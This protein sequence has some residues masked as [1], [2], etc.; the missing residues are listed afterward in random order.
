[1]SQKSRKT[2]IKMNVYD[3]LINSI[4]ISVGIHWI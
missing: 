4:G 2:R 1:M 3:Q